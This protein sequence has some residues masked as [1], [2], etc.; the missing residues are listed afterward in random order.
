MWKFWIWFRPNRK[1]ERIRLFCL[2]NNTRNEFNSRIYLN[3]ILLLSQYNAKINSK[4]GDIILELL[5]SQ[6]LDWVDKISSNK[7]EHS[8]N[9]DHSQ[10]FRIK[11][12]FWRSKTKMIIKIAIKQIILIFLYIIVYIL[13]NYK[14]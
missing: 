6:N 4:I 12:N 11:L 1:N 10:Y 9:G 14:P 3:Y 8:S 2:I 7:S 5:G 13:K